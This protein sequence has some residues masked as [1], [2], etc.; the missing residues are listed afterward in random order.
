MVVERQMRAPTSPLNLP[1][2]GNA[3][4]NRL[5]PRCCRP[6]YCIRAGMT[7]GGAR[8]SLVRLGGQSGH[9]ALD[10]VADPPHRLEALARGILEV[11]VDVALTRNDGTGVAAAHRD[12]EV[13]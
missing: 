4:R 13:R 3:P 9:P 11:P 5:I 8:D 10:L 6:C 7:S 2:A 12:D 1:P